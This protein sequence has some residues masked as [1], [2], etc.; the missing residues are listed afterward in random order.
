MP[1]LDIFTFSSTVFYTG[2]IF[3]IFHFL[4]HIIFLPAIGKSLKVRNLMLKK[5]ND[6]RTGRF[7][8]HSEEE[9]FFNL[10]AAVKKINNLEK[11]E[12]VY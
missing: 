3:I 2:V 9:A 12:K 6:E 1:Q 7:I 4:V 8:I 11:K 5:I 10:R